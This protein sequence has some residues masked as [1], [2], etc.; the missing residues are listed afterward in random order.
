MSH[1]KKSTKTCYSTK[2]HGE[3]YIYNYILWY[4]YI[5]KLVEISRFILVKTW[6]ILST[7][8]G[9]FTVHGTRR[10]HPAQQ[11]WSEGPSGL[12]QLALAD[13]FWSTFQ[14]MK[15]RAASRQLLTHPAKPWRQSVSALGKI[16]KQGHS[17]AMLSAS[18]KGTKDGL[19]LVCA[20]VWKTKRNDGIKWTQNVIWL[21]LEHKW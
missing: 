10:P 17:S 1:V 15:L 7:K 16:T 5:P 21:R 20:T 2:K 13:G 12:N 6:Y 19:R 4:I 18:T 9:R 8:N 3:L 14:I 11:Q